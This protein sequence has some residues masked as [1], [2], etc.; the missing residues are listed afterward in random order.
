MLLPE[1][2]IKLGQLLRVICSV[3]IELRWR[4]EILGDENQLALGQVEAGD[5]AEVCD[6]QSP[7]L[8]PLP[9]A[10]WQLPEFTAA[11][12]LFDVD[13]VLFRLIPVGFHAAGALLGGEICGWRRDEL[14][15]PQ[16]KGPEHSFTSAARTAV[17]S[18]GK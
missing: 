17:V 11:V 12:P 3:Q 6:L 9:V 1:L 18:A 10:E 4:A 14:F 8:A 5:S 13:D 7:S 16:I 15:S 2:S